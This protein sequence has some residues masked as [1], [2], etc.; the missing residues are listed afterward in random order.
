MSLPLTDALETVGGPLNRLP[1][2]S[3]LSL[4]GSRWGVAWF[5][6][7]EFGVLLLLRGRLT[8][9]GTILI[10]VMVEVEDLFL[11]RGLTGVTRVGSV[12]SRALAGERS[13]GAK[14]RIDSV[15][16]VGQRETLA[17]HVRYGRQSGH[18][19]GRLWQD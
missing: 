16:I 19:F 10:T 1:S 4:K 12:C 17:R 7:K 5:S 15:G 11:Q 2:S 18:V 8:D 3:K 13:D 14:G 9:Q 6:Q